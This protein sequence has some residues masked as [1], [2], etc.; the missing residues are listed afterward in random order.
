MNPTLTEPTPAPVPV[1]SVDV[2]IAVLTEKV[3][4]VIGDHERRITNLE[5]KSDTGGT[6]N[7]AIFG[8][9][10]AGVAIIV[11]LADKVTWH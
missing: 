9:I 10:L 3:N 1:S 2:A 6:R 7:A 8:P 11:A 4:Q 5:H